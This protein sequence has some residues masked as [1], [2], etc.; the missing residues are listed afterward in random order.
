MAAR[1]SSDKAVKKGKT[2]PPRNSGKTP[3]GNKTSGGGKSGNG[4]LFVLVILILLTALVLLVNRMNTYD[5]N[6]P[7]ARVRQEKRI[8]VPAAS[9][10]TRKNPGEAALTEQVAETAVKQV[11]IYFIKIDDR[12]ERVI[13]SPVRRRVSDKELVRESIQELLKGPSRHEQSRGFI[14]ALP[15]GL[16]LGNV[17][18]RNGTAVI[19]FNSILGEGAS[20]TILL[21]RLDQ[22]V[23]TATQ[24]RDVS[25]VEITINGRRQSTLGA[26]G[27]SIGGPLHRRE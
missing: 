7:G 10:E 8:E 9:V 24:F 22:I 19:D 5:T 2:S 11:N 18:V 14:T 1:D 26:D 17:R 3:R 21:N 4:P 13:L 12:T 25:S 23:Y 27:L 6:V 16:R 20:G 15:G